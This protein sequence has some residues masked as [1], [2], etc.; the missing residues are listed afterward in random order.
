MR[1]GR[2]F[3]SIAAVVV[4]VAGWGAAATPA[5]AVPGTG[6]P[7]GF[8]LEP[9]SILGEGFVGQVVDLNNDDLFCIRFL[10]GGN[11]PPGAFVFI[12]NVVP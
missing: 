2:F 9:E 5:G 3:L 6:C 12:D 11:I 10:S 8:Q 7:P 4:A 1:R